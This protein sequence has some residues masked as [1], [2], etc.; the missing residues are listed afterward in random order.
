MESFNAILNNL[1]PKGGHFFKVVE[2]LNEQI[3]DQSRKL[4]DA[5]CQISEP[6]RKK[7]KKQNDRNEQ[8]Y[9]CTRKFEDGI[10]DVAQFLNK[11]IPC[12][13]YAST[14]DTCNIND[15]SGDDESNDSEEDDLI[16]EDFLCWQCAKRRCNILFEK[17]HH[18]VVCSR[19]LAQIDYCPKCEKKIVG[20]IE[21]KH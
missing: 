4:I 9:T 3:N 2:R 18:N 15:S 20:T 10:I 14:L 19:C 6:S 12:G 16:L 1:A 8:I 11:V 7:S 17:C 5:V 21:I 13:Q